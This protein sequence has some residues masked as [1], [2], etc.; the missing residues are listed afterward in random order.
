[1]Y[2]T[3][4]D[5]VASVGAFFVIAFILSLVVADIIGPSW[6]FVDATFLSQAPEG[7]STILIQF[8]DGTNKDLYLPGWQALDLQQ[9]D[10]ICLLLREGGLY[11][12]RQWNLGD[13]CP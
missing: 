5:T 10:S 2:W 8:E 13:A 7:K 6:T 12:I 1:M 9:G 11:K 4:E 3:K